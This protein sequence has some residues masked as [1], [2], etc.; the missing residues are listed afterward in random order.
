[1]E[2]V[3]LWLSRFEHVFRAWFPWVA[4]SYSFVV[5]CTAAVLFLAM[6]SVVG[7]IGGQVASRLV[8]LGLRGGWLKHPPR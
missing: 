6:V 2:N 7:W 8:A 3:W 4:D 1:L 5:W